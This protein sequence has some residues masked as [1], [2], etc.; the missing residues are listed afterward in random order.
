M[1]AFEGTKQMNTNNS[2]LKN[3]IYTSILNDIIIGVYP[4]D[5]V[6]NE[7]GLM[8]KFSVSRAPVREALQ[9]RPVKRLLRKAR[10][11]QGRQQQKRQQ[12]F[13]KNFHAPF[14][15][16]REP[17]PRS[18]SHSD[19]ASRKNRSFPRTRH[20]DF[21]KNPQETRCEIFS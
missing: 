5:Q 18:G 9:I 8:E 11:A 12:Q 10:H 3:Q 17:F 4:P 1:Q 6:I 21:Q 20:A 16:S 14:L 2:S 7:K 19:T 15:F 13:P